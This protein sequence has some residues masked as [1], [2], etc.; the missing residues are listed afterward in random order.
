M[1]YLL[2]P[3]SEW[4]LAFSIL[5]SSAVHAA[6]YPHRIKPARTLKGQTVGEGPSCV[7]L[8]DHDEVYGK[9]GRVV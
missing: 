6:F 8:I 4:N 2:I 1:L 7:R 5:S 3:L 9:H